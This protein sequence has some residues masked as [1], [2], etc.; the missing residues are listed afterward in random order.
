MMGECAMKDLLLQ[1]FEIA[2]NRNAMVSDLW[3]VTEKEGS[4]KTFSRLEVGGCDAIYE[5]FPQG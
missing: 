1:L 2:S 3:V 5:A 4:K